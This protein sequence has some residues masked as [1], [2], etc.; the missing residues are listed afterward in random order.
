ML[1]HGSMNGG[2]TFK[3][4]AVT[5]CFFFFKKARGP[6]LLQPAIFLKSAKREF[7]WET[8]P[9]FSGRRCIVARDEKHG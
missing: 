7:L 5:F 3:S 9:S 6:S 4:E 8:A 1:T 2:G